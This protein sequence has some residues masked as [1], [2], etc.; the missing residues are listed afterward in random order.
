MSESSV[1]ESAK[2]HA[3]AQTERRDNKCSK[4]GYMLW[5]IFS[6]TYKSVNAWMRIADQVTWEGEE[7]HGAFAGNTTAAAPVSI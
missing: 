2:C 1:A 5:T 7:E 6:T 4:T 3:N